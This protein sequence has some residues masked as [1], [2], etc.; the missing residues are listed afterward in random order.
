MIGRK[1]PYLLWKLSRMKSAILLSLLLLT[2]LFRCQSVEKVETVILDQQE[3]K[4]NIYVDSCWNKHKTISIHELMTDDF[5]RNL[6]GITVANG[7][8]ELEAYIKSF[9][10]AFPNL[11]IEVDTMIQKDRQIVTTWT[12]EG[13]NTGKFAE[14]L[15]T[16]KKAKVSGVTLFQFNKDGKILREDTYYNELYLLQQL[17]YT[18]NS[19]NL[20]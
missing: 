4:V 2:G 20:K 17:G 9:I 3:T 19:P 5:T 12:F 7:S 6:N 15:P 16:G 13:T 8:V 10:R 11:K 18:L 14:C 1:T